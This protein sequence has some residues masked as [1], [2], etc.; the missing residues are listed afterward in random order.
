M[1]RFS[2]ADKLLA[3]ILFWKEMST[4]RAALRVI[5]DEMLKDIGISKTAAMCEANRHFWD[6]ASSSDG[7]NK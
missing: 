6:A 1:M 7:K 5:S 4:E 3:R 2:F